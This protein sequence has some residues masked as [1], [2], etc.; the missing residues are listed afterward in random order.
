MSTAS[1]TSTITTLTTSTGVRPSPGTAPGPSG[2]APSAHLPPDVHAFRASKALTYKLR[3]NTDTF[4]SR[5]DNYF[6]LCVGLGDKI[7]VATLLD[8]LYKATYHIFKMQ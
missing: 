7:K 3:G 6:D 2:T 5:S 1:G 8:Q 4:L